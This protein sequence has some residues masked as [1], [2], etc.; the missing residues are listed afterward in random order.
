VLRPTT[1]IACEATLL[2][3]FLA[4][5][6]FFAQP[7]GTPVF[8]AASVRPADPKSAP[9]NR[10]ANAQA[11]LRGGPG[12]ADPGR[13][14]YAN[15]TLQSLLITAYGAECKVQ[16]DC[17]QVVG[18]AC[19]RSDRYDIDAKIPV[20]T[21][22]D[23]FRI[24]LQALLAERFHMTLHHEMKDLPGYELTVAKGKTKLVVSP[25]AEIG[26]D[27]QA[28]PL[29]KFGAPGEYGKLL[30]AGFLVFPYEGTRATANHAIGREQ[31]LADITKLLNTLLNAHVVDKT[32]LSG[33]YDFT[34]DWVPDGVSLMQEADGP[35]ISP[36]H[37]IPTALED[38]LGLKLVRSKVAL[39]TIV[40]DGVDKV[41]TD[42]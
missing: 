13:I 31:S 36:P 41:P 23:Q 6:S 1:H 26:S 33:K 4:P 12:T 24:M 15:V 7:V 40:V 32:G 28:G 42:N 25:P 38:Q 20:G 18:P 16:E 29:V 34:L 3:A 35:E 22:T 10:S 11:T 37:G 2:L 27:D 39:D 21:T 17:D 9:V 5:A 14:S 30:R 19:L 8:D